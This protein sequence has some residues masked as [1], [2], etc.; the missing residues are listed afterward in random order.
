LTPFYNKEEPEIAK[1]L[2]E[3]ALKLYK[4]YPTL[5]YFLKRVKKYNPVGRL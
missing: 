4:K 1:P 5:T 2:N 3:L